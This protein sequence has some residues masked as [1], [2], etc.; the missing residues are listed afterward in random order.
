MDILMIFCFGLLSGISTLIF[1][2]KFRSRQAPGRG[3]VPVP[4]RLRRREPSR[5]LLRRPL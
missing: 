1:L 4:V 5:G 3:A 2:K